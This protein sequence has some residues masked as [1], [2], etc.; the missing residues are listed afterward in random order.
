M[1][2]HEVHIIICDVLSGLPQQP[3]RRAQATAIA[4]YLSEPMIF[5]IASTGFMPIVRM[6]WPNT[7]VAWPL[8]SCTPVRLLSAWNTS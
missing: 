1:N 5:S 4:A 2:S 6:T 7:D 8:T 3:G